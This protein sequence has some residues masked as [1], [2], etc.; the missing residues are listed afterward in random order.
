MDA[1]DLLKSFV[2]DTWYKAFVYLGGA[3][4]AFSLFFEVKGLTN[5]HLQL[6]S[7]GGF[8]LD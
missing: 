3:V 4:F 2:I 1:T 8:L 7:G 5:T 6:L